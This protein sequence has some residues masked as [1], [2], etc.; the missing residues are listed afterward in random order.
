MSRKLRIEYPGA[1]YHVMNRGDQR[2]DIFRDDHNRQKFLTTLGE[3][4]VKT[5]W[6][7]GKEIERLGWD[8]D[9]LRARRKGHRSKVMLARRLRQETTMSL[10][11]IA[12]RL[13]MGTWTYVSNLLNEPPETQ[14]SSGGVAV[15][16]IVRT[17]TCKVAAV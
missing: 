11:W 16:S 10:K 2:E 17:D 9:Q 13:Q 7:A 12:A 14:P 6:Q 15:V 3:A 5:E 4:C 1:M 8:E